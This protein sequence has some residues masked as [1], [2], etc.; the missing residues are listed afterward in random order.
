MMQPLGPKNTSSNN[1]SQSLQEIHLT[2]MTK[3]MTIPSKIPEKP[4]LFLR[5]QSGYLSTVVPKP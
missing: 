3:K 2:R 5:Y 1:E 4:A